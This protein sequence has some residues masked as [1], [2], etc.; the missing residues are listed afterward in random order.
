MDG[1][2]WSGGVDG[3]LVV[4]QAAVGEALGALRGAGTL[5][6][7]SPAGTAFRDRLGVVVAAVR[8]DDAALDD[9]RR[10]AARLADRYRPPFG[11]GVPR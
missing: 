8:R 10:E 9:V 1:A 5:A 7:E 6:W 11:E 4:A 2:G 3:D